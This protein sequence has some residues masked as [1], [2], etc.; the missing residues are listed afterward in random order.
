MFKLFNR[1]PG[2]RI[3]RQYARLMKEAANLQRKGDIKGYAS[4]VAEAEALLSTMEIK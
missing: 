1:N 3:Q 2:A 4:K